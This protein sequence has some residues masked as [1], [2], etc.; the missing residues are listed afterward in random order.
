M[1][2]D[3]GTE[4]GLEEPM[5]IPEHWRYSPVPE[6]RIRIAA[7]DHVA[8]ETGLTETWVMRIH[9]FQWQLIRDS[10]T[11]NKTVLVP[12]LFRMLMSGNKF[13]LAIKKLEQEI[14]GLRQEWKE[15]D[16]SLEKRQ[17]NGYT[18]KA[19][20]IKLQIME[21][22]RRIG[23]WQKLMDTK[24]QSAYAKRYNKNNPDST[25]NTK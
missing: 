14:E 24:T 20:E 25:G 5:K 16:T 10:V 19:Y 9:D 6:E 22:E 13:S 7:I 23:Q 15:L 8:K 3:K 21:K 12:R 1:R 4:K 17:K 18:P 11:A 2:K